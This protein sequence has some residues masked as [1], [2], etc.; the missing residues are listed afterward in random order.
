[1]HGVG[2]LLTTLPFCCKT[3]QY[4]IRLVKNGPIP[5]SFS[6]IFIF[7][8]FQQQYSFHFIMKKAQMACLRFKPGRRRNHG[9][10]AATHY[11][12]LVSTVRCKLM[13]GLP[14]LAVC[15][16]L[17]IVLLLTIKIN[18]YFHQFI[19]TQL[20]DQ[21]CFSSWTIFVVGF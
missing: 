12:R 16:Q 3:I 15:T 2:I 8:S 4:Y 19:I 1:M 13:K 17:D 7:F 9:A 11:L 21:S 6:F 20:I 18:K 5:A 10:I 14:S